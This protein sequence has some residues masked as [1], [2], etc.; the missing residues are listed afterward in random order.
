MQN[1]EFRLPVK[2]S[3]HGRHESSI[4]YSCTAGVWSVRSAV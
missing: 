4:G 2:Q 1:I 3:L